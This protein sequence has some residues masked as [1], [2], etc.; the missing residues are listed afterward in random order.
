MSEPLR[1]VV[2]FDVNRTSPNRMSGLHWAEKG[3]LQRIAKELARYCW[4][5]AGRPTLAPPV[6]VDIIVRRG[7]RMDADNALAGCR[8]LINGLFK[9]AVTQDDGPDFLQL[10]TLTQECGKSWKGAPE[11]EFIISSVELGG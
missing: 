11:V 3:D 4:E 10:G 5:R 7:R 2:Q 8:G 9:G 6:R 1:I